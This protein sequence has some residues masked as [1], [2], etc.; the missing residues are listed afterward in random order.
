MKVKLLSKFT[1][2]YWLSVVQILW[3]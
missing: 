3:M 2:D 1:S